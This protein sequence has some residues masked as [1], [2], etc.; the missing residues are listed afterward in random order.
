MTVNIQ[1]DIILKDNRIVLPTVF[2][3]TAVKRAH[4]GHQGVQK[5]KALMRSKIFFIGMD[6]AIEDE[7]NNCIACQSTGWPKPPAK[8]QS[9]LLPNEVWD[10]LNVDFI[11]PIPNRK[12]VFAIMDQRSRFS[13]AA[14][15]ASTSAK[16]LIKVFHVIFGQYGYPQKI[17]SD[18]GPPFKSKEINNY[19]SKRA[20]IH[21]RITP[22]WLQ[23]NGGIE[24]FMKPM[25]K[26]IQS[27]YIEQNDW[28]NALQEFLFSYRVTP[29][30]ST[31]I[32]PEDLMY[33]RRIRCSLPD[34]SNEINFK[35]MQRNLQR[36]DC[37]A[38]QKWLD[39]TTEK[40]R[41]KESLLN[42]GDRVL[43]K[44]T[45]QNKLSPMFKPYPYRMIG[46][47]GTMLTA[48]HV[49]TNHENNRNQTHFKSIP[50]TA[51]VPKQEQVKHELE[52]D[53]DLEGVGEVVECENEALRHN[54]PKQ[55]NSQRKTYPKRNRHPIHEWRKY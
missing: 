39:Y 24:H 11:G 2:H 54:R 31:E 3:R 44:Q 21:H 7:I 45:R 29:H 42:V 50:E 1:Y 13:F 12:Y 46:Q 10:T 30:S 25:M 32:A 49:S 8:I 15:T 53:L 9:S 41:L 18:N 40:R 55:D 35:S 28:E 27:A 19:F 26:V 36:N 16:N 34:I 48:K 17:I 6:K 23:A 33:S 38:K 20:I 4:V 43:V 5:T 47:N 14:V 37:L 52:E 22:Y 51:I